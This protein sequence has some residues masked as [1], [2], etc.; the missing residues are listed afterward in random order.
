[1]EKI[2]KILS[3]RDVTHDVRSYQ[4]EKPDKMVADV[5]KHLT[6]LGATPDTIVF[7]K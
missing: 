7:E 5:I 1:M 6:E 4:I 3:I 2:V